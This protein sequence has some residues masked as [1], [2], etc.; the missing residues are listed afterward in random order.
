VT[1]QELEAEILDQVDGALWSRAMIEDNRVKRPPALKRVVVAV[2]PAV[3]NGVGDECGIVADGLGEDGHAYVLADVSGR[4][5]PKRRAR[6]AIRGLHYGQVAHRLIVE[7]NNEG[8]LVRITHARRWT[9]GSRC[10][11]CTQAGKGRAEAQFLATGSPP[12]SLLILGERSA[13]S[14]RPDPPE[15]P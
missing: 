5:S 15:T 7:A 14:V 9:P 6:R 2:D 12:R 10:G 3:A 8:E 4:M 1:R 13:F 11:S